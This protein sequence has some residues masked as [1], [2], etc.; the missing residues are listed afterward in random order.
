MTCGSYPLVRRAL[1]ARAHAYERL[2]IQFASGRS[3][4]R[5]RCDPMRRSLALMTVLLVAAVPACKSV[6]TGARE[7]FAKTHSCPEDRVQVVVREDLKFGELTFGKMALPTPPDA[8]KDDAERL[9]KWKKD[10][11]GEQDKTREEFN[12][13]FD[14]FEVTGCKERDLLACGHRRSGNNIRFGD[15]ICFEARED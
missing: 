12:S 9:A 10:K 8:V 6:K 15:V 1:R 14:M 2:A 3:F 7:H 5:V 11:L 4:L 13:N